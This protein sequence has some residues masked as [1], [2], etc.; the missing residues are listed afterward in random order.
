MA[1]SVRLGRLSLYCINGRTSEIVAAPIPA[2]ELPAYVV[3]RPGPSA[4]AT[5]PTATTVPASPAATR[6]RA[7]T[8]ADAGSAR[9]TGMACL[10]TVGRMI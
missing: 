3:A 10:T 5:A 9:D 1:W 4:T 7:A 8:F 2:A 6:A